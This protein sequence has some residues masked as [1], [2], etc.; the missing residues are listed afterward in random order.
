MTLKS[1]ADLEIK[2]LGFQK[3]TLVSPELQALSG[4]HKLLDASRNP[5]VVW[6][7]WLQ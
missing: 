5:H 3:H 1:T 2:K 7:K 6:A 4:R